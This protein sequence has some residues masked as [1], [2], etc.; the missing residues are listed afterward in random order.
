MRSALWILGLATLGFFVALGV[1]DS[2]IKDSGG[3]GIVSFEVEFT[4]DNARETLEQWGTDGRAD[5]R[6]SLWLDYGFLVAYGAF[7]S[8]AV[9]ALVESMGWHRW[10]FLAT[11]PLIAAG[12]DAL[13]NAAL[14]LT[15]GQDG[16]QP[17]PFLAGVFA[18]VKFLL[19]TP[20]QL[21]V[22]GGFL[23]WVIRRVRRR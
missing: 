3:P 4:S 5:A 7:Y 11:F 19:L 12:A 21:F 13:E 9:L 23:V 14:L 10:E 17:W 8:L 2:N 16:D 1:I 22:L 15:I 20:A 18:S 6:F